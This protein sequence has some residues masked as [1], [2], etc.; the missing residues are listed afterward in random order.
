MEWLLEM[1]LMALLA[2]TIFHAFRLERAL[3]VLKRDR[4]A[5][6]ALVTDFNASTRAA[7]QGVERLHSAADGAGRQIERHIQGAARLRDD[8]QF[9]IDRGEQTADRLEGTMRGTRVN[10][11]SHDPEIGVSNSLALPEAALVRPQS[12]AERDLLKALRLA[13]A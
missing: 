13:R 9:L 12:Q 5:L 4:A 6:E 8:L 10:Q 7:E 1:A 3:G 11:R 2:A